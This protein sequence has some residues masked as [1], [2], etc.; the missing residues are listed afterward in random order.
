MADISNPAGTG[1]GRPR[2]VRAGE[3]GLTDRQR[4]IVLA[5]RSAVSRQ[6]YPPSM[7][8]IGAA[9][10]LTSTSSVAHQ[11]RSLEKK[12]VLY[13]DP[14]RPRAYR[15]WEDDV[16]APAP[17]RASGAG[18]QVPLVGRIAAGAPIT[19][20]QTSEDM[21]SLPRLLVGEGDL[22]AL[23]VHGDSM[24]G[25]AICDGDIVAV[26]RQP[27]AENG[28]VVAAMID[29]EA[30]VKRLRNSD[31]RS[32]LVPHNPAYEPIPADDATILGKVVA[33]LRSL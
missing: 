14:H 28:D 26:R 8:E 15:L 31:G 11:I 24:V 5:I 19:A 29:G 9:V 25:A 6:G 21:L 27:V 20:E 17:A 7:R 12:G 30:T 16:P 10:G 33:V 18:V 22:F 23:T 32:W 1:P 13:Q 4:A 2:G 3:D